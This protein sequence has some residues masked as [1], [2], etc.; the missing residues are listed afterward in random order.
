MLAAQVG[1]E[2]GAEGVEDGAVDQE[3]VKVV[4]AE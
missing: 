4:A 2:H 1:F 3:H